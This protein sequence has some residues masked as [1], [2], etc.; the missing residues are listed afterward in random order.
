MFRRIG[1][2]VCWLAACGVATAGPGDQ[3]GQLKVLYAGNPGSD[4]ERDYVGFLK[5]TFG[6]VDA[7]DYRTFRD[8]TAEGH[9]VVILD[10]TSIQAR[11]AAGR[12]LDDF[13]MNYPKPTP[14][15]SEGYSRPTILIGGSGERAVRKLRLKIDWGCLCLNDHAHGM[16]LDHPIFRGP[17]PVD[18][19]LEEVPTPGEYQATADGKPVGPTTQAWRVQTPKFFDNDPGLVARGDQFEE[20]PDA[21]AISSG[22]NSKTPEMVALGRHGNFFL[23]GF[24]SPP[25]EMTPSARNAFLNVVCYIRKFDGHK[26]VVRK[27]EGGIVTRKLTHHLA[28]L[29]RV[30]LEPDGLR[31]AYPAYASYDA[32]KYKQIRQMELRVFR[33]GFPAEVNDRGASDPGAYL[34]WV[35][36]NERWL[37][38]GAYDADD[39]IRAIAVDEDLKALGM[40]NREVKTLDACVALLA[41][42]DDSGRAVRV[43]KRYTGQ[44][45]ADA[46]AWKSWLDA[47]RDRLVFTEVGGFRFVVADRA[48]SAPS[49]SDRRLPLSPP[50]SPRKLFEPVKLSGSVEPAR[51][52]AGQGAT[53]TFRLEIAPRWHVAAKAG[54]AG[55]E[56]PVYLRLALP[57]G[58]EVDGEW[59]MPEAIFDA[60]GHGRYEGTVEFRRKVKVLADAPLGSMRITPSAYHQACDPSSCRPATLKSVD[61]PFEVVKP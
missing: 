2:I 51:A 31:K 55:P 38:P 5:G 25:G 28:G 20:A 49:E 39:G 33:K 45:F 46:P 48:G 52:S 6:R 34:A 3:P 9:D 16:K 47:H 26:P 22:I 59:I 42:G 41:S 12:V 14:S 43:L 56:V 35:E 27:P 50:G 40:D 24:A 18:V 17:F 15:L 8:E 10:W 57:P 1:A 44:D 32:G 21:E 7:V 58:L 29:A 36:A 19:K 37:V 11:D 23:W 54:T 60:E 30:V 61:I 53:V 13:K 4:R